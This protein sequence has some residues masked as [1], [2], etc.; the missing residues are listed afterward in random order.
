MKDKTSLLLERILKSEIGWNLYWGK[1]ISKKLQ[2][3]NNAH[4][5]MYVT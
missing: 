2:K 3:K 1:D 4:R 5:H